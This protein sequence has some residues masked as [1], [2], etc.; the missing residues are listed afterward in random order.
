MIAKATRAAMG[1]AR[2]WGIESAAHQWP[3]ETGASA[4]TAHSGPRR[5]VQLATPLGL[6]GLAGTDD[7]VSEIGWLTNDGAAEPGKL[8]SETA[9]VSRL[10]CGPALTEAARQLRA[11]FDRRLT[12]FDLN[13]APPGTSFQQRVWAAIATIP[14]GQTTDYAGIAHRVESAPRAVG[15]ACGANRIVIVIPCHR[16]LARNGLGGYSGGDGLDTK[17]R[18]LAFEGL[19]IPGA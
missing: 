17:R 16:V 18:L 8:G 3:A 9:H 5:H 12:R 13:L 15:G 7:A 10:S 4:V 6:L 2:P 14:F 1:V 11:W 19:S